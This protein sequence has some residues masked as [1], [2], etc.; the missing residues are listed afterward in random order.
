MY[1]SAIGIFIANIFIIGIIAVNNTGPGWE[2]GQGSLGLILLFSINLIRDTFI[3]VYCYFYWKIQRCSY[4]KMSI[5][6]Y[7]Y[8]IYA[9]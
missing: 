7:K 4:W 8:N 3:I 9:E 2:V 1:K 5:M 6:Q